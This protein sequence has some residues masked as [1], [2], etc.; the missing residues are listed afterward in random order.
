MSPSCLPCRGGRAVGGPPTAM[1]LA[2]T[3]DADAGHGAAVH[4]L[5][6]E[7]SEHPG[8]CRSLAA[9]ANASDAAARNRVVGQPWCAGRW[10]CCPGAPA[11]VAFQA[12]RC[13]REC[14]RLSPAGCQ[15]RSA[16]TC[17]RGGL[18]AK[19][20]V[21]GAQGSSLTS[22]PDSPLLQGAG[23]GALL[24]GLWD[25]VRRA[26]EIQ[27]HLP[28]LRPLTLIIPAKPPCV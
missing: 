5:D 17:L 18:R 2:H 7:P 25:E 11:G 3:A 6:V 24:Q 10:R 1:V 21:Q 15:L 19:S 28:M 8:A 13:W 26:R 23:H 27:D 4:V 14:S 9:V 16:S 22:N 20:E 12:R